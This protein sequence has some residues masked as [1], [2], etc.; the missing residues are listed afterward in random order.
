V[1]A[2]ASCEHDGLGDGQRGADQTTSSRYDSYLAYDPERAYNDCG[3]GWSIYM[4]QNFPG[5]ANPARDVD[6]QP[7]KNGWPFPYD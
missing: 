4:R 1:S 3:D 5:F 7:M 2:R 6:G